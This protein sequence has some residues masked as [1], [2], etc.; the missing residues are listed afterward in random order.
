MNAKT[1]SISLL[2]MPFQTE[3]F[4]SAMTN[5]LIVI[6]MK[7]SQSWN[8]KFSTDINIYCKMINR[9]PSQKISLAEFY[10]LSPCGSHLSRGSSVGTVCKINM[11]LQFKSIRRLWKCGTCSCHFLRTLRWTVARRCRQRDRTI[12]K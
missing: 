2:L 5:V 1:L 8:F 9:L 4:Q 6:L 11:L 12:K 3:P 7:F 10:P